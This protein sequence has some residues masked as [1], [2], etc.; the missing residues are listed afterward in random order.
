MQQ[1]LG[2]F[3]LDDFFFKLLTE[4]GLHL[5]GVASDS[6]RSLMVSVL[7]MFASQTLV[8]AATGSND[9]L[10]NLTTKSYNVE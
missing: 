4:T 2:L 9:K 3:L 5:L 6:S 10:L 8:V 1:W 7:L